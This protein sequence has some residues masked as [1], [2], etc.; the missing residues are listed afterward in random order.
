MR[1]REDYLEEGRRLRRQ[2]ADEIM[3]LE[4]IRLDKVN[5]LRSGGVEGK[6]LSSLINRKIK[7]NT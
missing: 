2:H 4:S 7:F 1:N 3:K 6:Y 5:E